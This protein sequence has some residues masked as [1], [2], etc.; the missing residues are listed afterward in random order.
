MRR[1]IA[2][3][4]GTPYCGSSLLNLLLDSQQEVRGL[5][6]ALNML[7]GRPRAP[8][9][10]CGEGVR[11]CPLYEVADPSRFYGSIFDFYPDSRMLVD[12]SK[13]FSWCLGAHRFEPEFAYKPIVL[14]KAPH[15]FAHSW[16]GHHP[17]GSL[18]D[19]YAW[20]ADFYSLQLDWLSGQP[21]FMPGGY[22]TITYRELAGQP[23]RTLKALCD[24]LDAS[25]AWN[26]AW[27]QSDSHIVG[28]NRIVSAQTS[29]NPSGIACDSA[30]LSG[31]YRGRFHTIFYDAQWSTDAARVCA[32][33]DLYHDFGPQFG[34]LLQ[35]LGQPDCRQL[36]CELQTRPPS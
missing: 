10:R 12:S 31:K 9:S 33:R 22:K 32:F 2:L 25:Y 20:Y 16:L 23:Q 11:G 5:G 7:P 14:S 15:E 4:I 6:E 34:G 21:W 19:A 18:R 17:G 29:A 8:C 3:I 27:W 13:E 1:T 26:A 30:Y 35:A 24:F 36:R 28:G